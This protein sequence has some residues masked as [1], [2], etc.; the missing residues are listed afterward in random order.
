M[1]FPARGVADSKT[2]LPALISH[3]CSQAQSV[4][5]VVTIRRVQPGW[6]DGAGTD[7]LSTETACAS[8]STRAIAIAFCRGAGRLVGLRRLLASA[9]SA[10]LSD[11]YHLN[12][13]NRCERK[14]NDTI[15]ETNELII[16]VRFLR[17]KPNQAAYNFQTR[18]A[19]RPYFQSPS[20]T[21]YFR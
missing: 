13:Y 5:A 1:A 2:S 21:L 17:A 6:S 11:Y 3:D 4:V 8:K 20:G 12:S 10:G 16:G 19:V 14:I 7:W 9:A 15:E 18:R